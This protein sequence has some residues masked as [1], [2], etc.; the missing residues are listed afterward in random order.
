M[1]DRNEWEG[2]IRER[3]SH[4]GFE[5]KRDGFDYLISDRRL[6][7]GLPAMPPTRCHQLETVIE[8]FKI[9]L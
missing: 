6:D 5:L 2:V 9:E 3:L 4:L 8:F 1:I 7:R